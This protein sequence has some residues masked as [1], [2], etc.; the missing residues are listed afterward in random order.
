MNS[1]VAIAKAAAATHQDSEDRVPA[2]VVAH[3][4]V[5]VPSGGGVQV[6]NAEHMGVL[7]AAG[8]RLQVIS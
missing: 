7:E 4:Q 3:R 8:F 5:L 1:P 2:L 6:C